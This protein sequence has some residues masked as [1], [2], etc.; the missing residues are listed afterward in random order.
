MLKRNLGPV[1]VMG[2]ARYKKRH[3]ASA[4]DLIDAARRWQHEFLATQAGIAFHAFLGNTRGEFAD[5][6]LAVDLKSFEDMTRRHSEAESSDVFMAM[7]DAQSVRL[8]RSAILKEDVLPPEDFSCVE[9]GTFRIKPEAMATEEAVRRASD[10]IDRTYLSG[11]DNTRC[12]FIGRIDDV[13]YCEVAFGRT[14]A[15]TKRICRGYVGD[16][17]CQPLLELFD[18]E[19]VDLDFWYVL[20]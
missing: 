8:C 14:L 12:H 9:F 13:T 15:E 10:H 7:L 4:D 6:I 18:P 17:D 11:S 19:S 16:P 1:G 3:D 2:F 5:A 20:A